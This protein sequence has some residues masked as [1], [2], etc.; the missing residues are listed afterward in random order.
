MVLLRHQVHKLTL[1][2]FWTQAS[3]PIKYWSSQKSGFLTLYK[4]IE[5][6]YLIEMKNKKVD[7]IVQV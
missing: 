6:S 7:N 1:E 2:L 5:K 4:I 3:N